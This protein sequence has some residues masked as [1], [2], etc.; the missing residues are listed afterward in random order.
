MLFK[1]FVCTIVRRSNVA[2]I[3]ERL[4]NQK[5]IV[6]GAVSY[7]KHI[8]QVADF[9]HYI[10]SLSNSNTFIC[11]NRASVLASTMSSLAN[12][13]GNIEK[14]K[15]LAAIKAVN[16]HVKAGDV[17]GVGSGSTIVYAVARLAERVREE[18]L[19]I[20]CVPT[21][22]QAKQLITEN[23]LNLSSLEVMPLSLIHI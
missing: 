20:Q 6:I 10:G 7:A 23:G 8:S 16:N 14:A 3:L 12:D 22:F 17:V 13:N 4:M 15:R 11:K 1:N 9:V 19:S 2:S 21:S 5:R 18:H